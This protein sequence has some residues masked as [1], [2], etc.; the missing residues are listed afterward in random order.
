MS[1]PQHNVMGGFATETEALGLWAKLKDNDRYAIY[2]V[3]LGFCIGKP[4]EKPVCWLV[5][6]VDITTVTPRSGA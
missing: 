4:A 5:L 3:N 6:P 1:N 2:E